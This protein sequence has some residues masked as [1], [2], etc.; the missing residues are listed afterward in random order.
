[1]DGRG[2]RTFFEK[3]QICLHLSKG[4]DWK[5]SN[6][7]GPHRCYASEYIYTTAVDRTKKTNRFQSY[8]LI[9]CIDAK[10]SGVGIAIGR[11][12]YIQSRY[13]IVRHKAWKIVNTII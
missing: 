3:A 8:E 11:T 13:L 7:N 4:C 5:W 6:A 1:M 12:K 9:L 2:K 10:H